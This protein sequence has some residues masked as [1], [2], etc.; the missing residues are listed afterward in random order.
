MNK[1]YG[2]KEKDVLGLAEFIKQNN[3]NTKTSAFIE[4]AKA[5]GKAQGTIRNLYYALAKK[6]RLDQEFC[7]KYLGGTP[8]SVGKIVEFKRDEEENL[9][10]EILKEKLKGRSV[11]S[12]ISSLSKGDEKIALRY[13]NKFRNVVKNNP[14]LIEKCYKELSENQ[15]EN[16]NFNPKSIIKDDKMKKLKAEINSLVDKISLD[17]KKENQKLKAKI[18]FLEQE[19]AKFKQKLGLT[20]SQSTAVKFFVNGRDEKIFS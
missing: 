1:I 11:R 14:E 13:Q 17:V 5:S 20:T 19:N 6:S 8:L 4:Y 15:T 9:V 2:Y 18:A 16:Q 12:I 3:A 7:Q 10:K